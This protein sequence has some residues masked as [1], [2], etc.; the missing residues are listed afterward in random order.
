MANSQ[1]FSV[2]CEALENES[3]LDRLE[4][5]GTVRLALKNAGLEAG[6]VT[7]TQLGVVI[8]KIL[9]RELEARGID[10]AICPRLHAALAGVENAPTPEGPE[11]VF[12]RLGG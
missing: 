12:G 5:R 3:D 1:A 8:D 4:A 9:P 2:L 11:A 7:T 6:T 10:Q